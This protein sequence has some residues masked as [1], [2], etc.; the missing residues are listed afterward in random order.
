MLLMMQ[1]LLYC[2]GKSLAICSCS[3][4]KNGMV[5][6]SRIDYSYLYKDA[7]TFMSDTHWTAIWHLSLLQAHHNATSCSANL[8]LCRGVGRVLAML[9][10]LKLVICRQV[11]VH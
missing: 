3:Y 2:M 5:I 10:R 4:D 8:A 6:D 7:A 11:P 1:S 9:P